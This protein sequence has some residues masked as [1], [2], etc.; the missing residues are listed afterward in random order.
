ME[1]GP[2]PRGVSGDAWR[3]AA[4]RSATVP[5]RSQDV[6]V[7]VRPGTTPDA[8]YGEDDAEAPS[9]AQVRSVLCFVA[10]PTALDTVA[11]VP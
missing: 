5:S 10:R 3:G 7:A 9:A 4:G 6:P 2:R 8:A 11:A 1:G